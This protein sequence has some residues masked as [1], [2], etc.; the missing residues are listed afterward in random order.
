MHESGR[1]TAAGI[2][3]HR[4]IEADT[5]RLARGPVVRLGE[6]RLHELLEIL[7]PLAQALESAGTIPYPNAIGVP[8]TTD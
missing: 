2:D 1:A 8:P 6:A 5:D 4:A 3:A 7:R